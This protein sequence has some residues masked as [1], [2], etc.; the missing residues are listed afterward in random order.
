MTKDG[1][2]EHLNKLLVI[3]TSTAVMSIALM[4]GERLLVESNQIVERRHSDKLLPAIKELITSAGL[5]MQDIDGVAVGRGPGTYT[6]V[7]IGVT[8]AKTLAWSLSVPLLGI[9]S[10]EALAYGALSETEGGKETGERTWLVPMMN[11][12][13]DQVYA[14][15]Y[16]AKNRHWGCLAADGVQLIDEWLDRIVMLYG[17]EDADQAPQQ[18]IFVGEE[19]E[20]EERIEARWRDVDIRSVHMQEQHMRASA[21]GLLAQQRWM[22]GEQDDVH[23]MVPNYTQLSE[24]E[25]NLLA[26]HK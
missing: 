12:R 2:S 18:I 6:G 4:D 7:R 1:Q 5:T 21:L 25:A 26:K 24:A 11:A 23:R 8:T 17:Q 9:S 13:R 15:L 10:L 14:G 3:D 16:E 20:L 22:S 19:L